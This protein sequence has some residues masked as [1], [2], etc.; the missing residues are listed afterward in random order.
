MKRYY[1]TTPLYYVNAKP[2]IGHSYTTV[3][4]DALARFKRLMGYEV[5]FLTGT[6]EHGQKVE[7][8]SREAGLSPQEFTDKLSSE[9]KELWKI[10]DIQYDDF[11]RTTQERHVKAVQQV[12]KTLHANGEIKQ[13]KYEGAYCTPCESFWTPRE[14]KA[15]ETEEKKCPQCGCPLE[16]IQE[17]NYFFCISKHQAWLIDYIKKNPQFIQPESRRNE[18]LRFLED[19]ELLDLCI[20]R[21]KSRLKWGIESPLSSDHVTYVWFDALINYISA[22]GYPDHEKQLKLFWPANV[23]LI[24]KDILRPHTVYWPIMLHALGLEPPQCVFAHGWW[25]VDETKMSKS[26][27]N[28]V[29]PVDVVEE[30]GVDAYRYFL[31]RE[32]PFGQDGTYSDQAITLRYNVD[33]ANDLGNLLHRTLSM[34]QK[35]FDGVIPANGAKNAKNV[36]RDQVKDLPQRMEVELDQF[37]YGACLDVIWSVIGAANKFIDKEAP[38]VLKKENKLKELTEVMVSLCEVLRL[39][40]QAISPFMPEAAIKIWQQLGLK[41]S[42]VHESF[43]KVPWNYFDQD[44]MTQKADPVFPRRETENAPGPAR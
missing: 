9:F 26:L 28:V 33:L 12:W 19:N 18:T 34:L 15:Q 16:D 43:Y 36:L 17:D 5:F 27:G 7:K 10:L 4:A 2:H 11:I 42:P 3:A 38:W 25:L 23:H 13:E 21:P 1:L 44:T 32:V 37:K 35:Y 22:C 8:A 29:N 31:L 30:Y 24:G 41:D 6:D 20:S 40:A 39:V 14:L